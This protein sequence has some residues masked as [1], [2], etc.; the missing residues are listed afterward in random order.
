M[1]Q[2]FIFCFFSLWKVGK[3]DCH[4]YVDKP[5]SRGGGSFGCWDLQ[6]HIALKPIFL[7]WKSLLP[8]RL[9]SLADMPARSRLP[10]TSLHSLRTPLN[11]SSL[12]DDLLCQVNSAQH[13]LVIRALPKRQRSQKIEQYLM[14]RLT[15]WGRRYFLLLMIFRNRAWRTAR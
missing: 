8:W 5:L 15:I 14:P 7:A 1:Y 9:L 3:C 2:C 10:E 6:V 4:S 13:Y 12:A 11:T